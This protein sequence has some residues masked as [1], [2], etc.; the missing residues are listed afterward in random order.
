MA[1]ADSAAGFRWGILGTARINRKFVAGLRTVGHAIAIVGSRDPERGRAAAAEY[2]AARAGSYDDVLGAADV[3]AVYISLPNSLHVEWTLRAAAAG[4]HVLCE[5]PMATNAAD[6]GRMVAAC[7]RSGV[8]LVEAFMYRYHPQWRR[9][10][11]AIGNG[12]IGEPRLVRAAFGFVLR[13]PRNIR[14][15]GELGGG[16]LMDVGCYTA[17]AARWFLG[18][19]VRVRG[20]AL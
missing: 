15:I 4:K 14:L 11:D 2:G 20:I 17:N 6:C 19:P 1:S 9:V 12:T 7:E 16:A 18:E 13:D 8:H 3:D 10:R 5:K